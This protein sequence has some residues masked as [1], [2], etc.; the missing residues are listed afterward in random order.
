MGFM[1]VTSHCYGCKQLF[2]YNPNK[3][4]SIRINGE[5]E[6]VCRSCIERANPE[7]IKNGLDPISIKADAYQPEECP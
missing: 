4:P 2:S 7:R 3:V 1:L 5:R 6:P